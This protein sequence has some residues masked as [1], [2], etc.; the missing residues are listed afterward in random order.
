MNKAV[1]YARYSS[2]SQNEQS[3][4]TQIDICKQYAKERKLVVVKEYVDKGISGTSA[5]RPAFKQ[6]INDSYNGL[7]KYVIVYKL[8]RFARDEFDD[9]RFERLLNDNGVKRLSAT[10]VIPED[11]FSGALIKAV[12][13][14]N[15][16]NYSRLLSQRVT[17]GL[18][19]NVEKGLMVGGSVTWGYKIVNKKYEIDEKSAFY[20]RMIF[21]L[22][23]QG[24]TTKAICKD[25][26]EKG[27][28]NSNG[29]NF[30][31]QHISK[32][33]HNK[34]YIGVFEYK[35]KEYPDFL[36]PIIDKD[37]FDI[38]QSKL[39]KNATKKGRIRKNTDYYLSGKLF[40]GYCNTKMT[41][42]SGTG[43][44]G[45]KFHY[46][47]CPN[48]SCE[49]N[50]IKKEYLEHSVVDLV[51][52]HVLNSDNLDAWIRNSIKLYEASFEHKD[53]EVELIKSRIT[54]VNKKINNIVQSLAKIGYSEP[55]HEELEKLEKQKFTLDT[56]LAVKESYSPRVI[57][58][59]TMKRMF[60]QFKSDPHSPENTKAIIDL[61]V[62][63]V[64]LY[65]DFVRVVINIEQEL[66]VERGVSLSSP[67]LHHRR[68]YTNPY[69]EVIA[70][71]IIV[72][73]WLE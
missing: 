3:I 60:L 19:K 27:I 48:K 12:T 61:L 28:T 6:M 55:L 20:V 73:Y 35:G 66:M 68:A 29:K 32:I 43:R 1:I 22:F 50:S 57:H 34:R 51:F 17:A 69:I 71:Y 49:K 2:S 62:K 10:E 11:Y 44:H 8:D 36:P 46:Y 18:D 41:G 23:K 58:T 45:G 59:I 67:Q 5:N 42:Y 52:D 64:V 26:L 9:I 63:K 25:L 30:Q 24:F 38:V 40:C 31:H 65:D 56:E 53:K 15:N 47:K 72:N 54:G 37:T 13:R 70:G 21:D 33:L 14:L 39:G 16:E 4:D 7:F